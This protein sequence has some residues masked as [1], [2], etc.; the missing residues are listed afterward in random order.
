M[1]FIYHPCIKRESSLSQRVGPNRRQQVLAWA[2]CHKLFFF[3]CLFLNFFYCYFPDT[4]FFL[5]YSVVT[6]LH[7]HVYIT[8]SLII[9]LHHKWLDID[10][11]ATQQDLI[12]NPFQKQQFASINPKLPI[13]PTQPFP[14]FWPW[15]GSPLVFC[16]KVENKGCRPWQ[17]FPRG[18]YASFCLRQL[19]L[20]LIIGKII[21][22]KCN[23]WFYLSH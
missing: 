21:F 2:W 5:L 18:Q 14:L 6:Q 9:M 11:W 20:F 23:T 8:F 17:I 7:M 15:D 4:I 10:L 22:K 13:C 16:I 3:F 1:V 12:A 19:E